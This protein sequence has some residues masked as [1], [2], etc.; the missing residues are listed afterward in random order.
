MDSIGKIIYR[1]GSL[2]IWVGVLFTAVAVYVVGQ[3]RWPGQVWA[4]V[5]GLIIFGIIVQCLWR[6]IFDKKNE[7]TPQSSK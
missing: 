2:A 7:S 3:E 1:L 6:W 5:I 4:P